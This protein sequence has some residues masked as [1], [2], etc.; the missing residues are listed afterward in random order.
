MWCDVSYLS[1]LEVCSLQG[2]IQIHVYLSLPYLFNKQSSGRQREEEHSTG[3]L[4]ISWHWLVHIELRTCRHYKARNTSVE[5]THSWCQ[6]CIDHR[7]RH[8]IL[9]GRIMHCQF[10]VICWYLH[11]HIKFFIK[12]LLKPSLKFLHASKIYRHDAFQITHLHTTVI[13]SGR[14]TQLTTAHT[15]GLRWGAS[16]CADCGY[17]PGWCLSHPTVS[18]VT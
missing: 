11:L 18:E 7:K 15:V 16:L 4:T 10:L 12:I 17:N 2:I 6:W 14:A 1:A 9:C 5:R 3:G 8:V 13:N